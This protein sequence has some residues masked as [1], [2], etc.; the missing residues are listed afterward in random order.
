MT[1]EIVLTLP[2]DREFY[3]IAQLVLGG[4]AVRLDLTFETLEDLQ[5]ALASVLERPD[6]DGDVNVTLRVD[7]RVV[8]TLVG[9]FD[10]D[11]L[12]AHLER[13]TRDELSVARLL[14]TVVDRVEIDDRDEGAWIELTKTVAETEH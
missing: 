1:D 11:A 5:L 8:R 7:G 3:G 13:Q 6:D 9:P 12:R 10:V 2:R 4:L 14:D